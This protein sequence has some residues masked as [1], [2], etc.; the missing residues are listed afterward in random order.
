MSFTFN[1][2]NDTNLNEIKDSDSCVFKTAQEYANVNPAETIIMSE[3]G[4]GFVIKE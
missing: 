3:Y 2:Q 1:F 4:D